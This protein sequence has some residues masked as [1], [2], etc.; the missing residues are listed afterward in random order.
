V[1]LVEDDPSIRRFVVL[2]LEHLDIDL[3]EAASLGEARQQLAG[4]PLRLLISDLMLPDGSGLSLLQE[5]AA[6]PGRHA[7]VRL[8]AFS[9]GLGAERRAQLLALGI[10]E[11]LAKPV[12]LSALEACVQRALTDARP[13]C[14]APDAS[15]S[16]V[17]QYFGGDQQL[18][19]A[20]RATCLVQFVADRQQGD[21]AVSVGDRAAL[22]RLAHSLKSVLQTLGCLAACKEATALERAAEGVEMDRVAAGWARLRAELVALD[23][24]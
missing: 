15:R 14:P 24:E 18:H 4:A 8:V 7:G 21:R 17:A 20:Y 3:L 22:R 6:S 1:L 9:A 19:D 16:V 5:L 12:S 23:P 13:A 2:A 10:D 11:L